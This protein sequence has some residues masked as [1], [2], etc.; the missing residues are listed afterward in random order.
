[1][2]YTPIILRK[3]MFCSSIS[4]HMHHRSKGG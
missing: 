3:H 2:T 4:I 1:V